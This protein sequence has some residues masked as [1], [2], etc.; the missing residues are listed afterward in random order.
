MTGHDLHALGAEELAEVHD[1]PLVLRGE[2]GV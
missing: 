2:P 1:A